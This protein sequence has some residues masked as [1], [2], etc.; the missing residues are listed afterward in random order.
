[1][2]TCSSSGKSRMTS[3]TSAGGHSRNSSRNAATLRASA[4]K[5]IFVAGADLKAL[6][7]QAQTSGMRAFI[8]K[9]QQA[10]NRL[11]GLKIPS[12]AAIHG[13]SAGGGYEVALAC[14]YRVATDDPATRIGL[15]E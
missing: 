11:A 14:D 13:A 8:A 1:M 15:P 2:I 10:F 7:Q 3:A 9:G 12:V 5:S 6:L 4:K